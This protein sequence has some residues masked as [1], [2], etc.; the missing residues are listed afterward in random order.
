MPVAT[1]SGL[2]KISP[3]IP[4]EISA[5][6]GRGKFIV[7]RPVR[8]TSTTAVTFCISRVNNSFSFA[9]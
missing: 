8:Q 9:R 1:A 6:T 2:F 3:E 7:D 5:D 4:T